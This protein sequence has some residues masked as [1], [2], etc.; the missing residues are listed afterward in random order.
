MGGIDQPTLKGKRSGRPR[1]TSNKK[2]KK[3]TLADSFNTSRMQFPFISLP[4]LM[5]LVEGGQKELM[6]GG[7]SFHACV[8]V[9]VW[10]GIGKG[11][12]LH[13]CTL[14][15]PVWENCNAAAELE[16]NFVLT[17]VGKKKKKVGLCWAPC[18]GFAGC[19]F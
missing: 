8:C 11:N 4:F 6:F 2:K 12:V 9:C 7:G 14:C 18:D 16:R 1:M 10:S 15:K 5:V 17:N 3:K 19:C 13:I